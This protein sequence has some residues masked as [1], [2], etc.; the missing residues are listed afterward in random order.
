ML[1]RARQAVTEAQVENVEF[2]RAGAENLPVEDSST[3]MVVVNGIFNLNP[4]RD[5]IFR[6]LARVMRPGGAVYAAE[7]VLQGPLPRA[8]REGETNWFA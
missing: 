2:L 6:E 5:A 3:D 4:A 8:V 7:L 1:A